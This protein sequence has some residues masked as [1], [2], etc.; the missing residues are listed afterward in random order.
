MNGA[1]RWAASY[2]GPRPLQ[3]WK[4]WTEPASGDVRGKV[5]AL[6]ATTASETA[7]L[8][9]EECARCGSRHGLR[10]GG[11]AY[12]SSPT[13]GRLGWPVRVCP[14]CPPNWSG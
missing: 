5:L 9:G 6:A 10:S 1:A 4:E 14:N 13:A 12:T 8:R 3:V 11:Y 7:R 2:N